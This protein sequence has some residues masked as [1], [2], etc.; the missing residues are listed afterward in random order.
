MC[1]VQMCSGWLL[2][3]A[4]RH[5]LALLC[6]LIVWNHFLCIWSGCKKNKYRYVDIAR[7][8][9]NRLLNQRRA[10]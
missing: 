8:S 5:S 7:D 9:E 3:R 10:P 6:F 1:L 4:P 2:W